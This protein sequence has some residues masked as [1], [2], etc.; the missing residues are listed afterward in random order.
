MKKVV[1]IGGGP[2]GRVTVH[3]LHAAKEEFDITLIKDEEINVNRCAVPYGI[4]DKK[5]V[6]K[7][8]IPNSLVTDFGAKLVIDKATKINTKE[9]FVLTEKG[10]RYDYDYLLLATGSKPIIPLIEG[11]NLGNITTVRSKQDMERL[12]EFAKKYKKCVIVGGGYIGVE[13]AVVLK[14]LG[15]DVTIVEMLE[16]ILLA[17][18]DDDFAI[19]V[20]N[21][22][23]EKGINVVTGDKV[24][25]FEGDESVKKV[26]LESGEKIDTDFVVI[27]VGV[28]PNVE[29]AEKSGIKVS[30]FGIKTDEY[31]R[32]NIENIFAA[33]DCAEKKSFI[34]KRTIR[35]EFGT[36]AV[37]MGRVVGANIAGKNVKFPGV[38]NANVSTV[39]EY[40]F[41]SAGLIEKA[42]KNEGIDVVVGES[43]VMDMYP[44]MDGVSKIKTKLVFERST[45][46][47]I[48]GTV[49][50]KGHCVAANIDFISF[51]I[52]KSATIDEILLHQYSTHPELAAKPS[53]NIY[54]FAARDALKKI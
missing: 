46:K 40:S 6:D 53:D 41:G 28:V 32:T 34:T 8:C 49:L 31:L 44:M 18:L 50:R 45:G 48:G 47:L 52:Q 54:V 27:S 24:I 20:E 30:K 21:H 1:I 16:H 25:A 39:F 33:G 15:L 5:P 3:T 14:R 51:A 43:E 22:L 11:V 29:L 38:I 19:E 12:R 7:F 37:F 35:G 17:T 9:N 42:V 36:N 26:V 23:K 2:A 13:V 10:D 4:I